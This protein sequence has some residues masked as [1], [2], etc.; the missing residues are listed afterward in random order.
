MLKYAGF[1]FLQGM[2]ALV[3]VTFMTFAL[4][5]VAGDP[6]YSYVRVDASAK[7]I[8]MARERLG[9]NRPLVVQ[10][11]KHVS[12]YAVG[13][14]G[15]SLRP[16]HYPVGKLIAARIPVSFQ[17]A[18]V[19][20]VFIL[21][22][23]VPIGVLA[24]VKRGTVFD[25][26][27]KALALGGQSIPTFWL[28]IVLIVIFAVWLEVLPV[29]GKGGPSSFILPT[30]AAAWSGLAAVV[31]ITRS[32]MLEILGTD[33][34]RTARAKGLS[35]RMVIWTHAFRNALI[36][37]VTLAGLMLG[38]M[39]NGLV[40]IEIIFAWPGLG[41]QGV[42]AVMLRD[43]PVLIALVM[44]TMV[45]YLL[46]NFAVDVLYGLIDPRIKYT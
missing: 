41:A 23:A 6:I 37:I 44:L 42:E 17:L 46:I 25:T 16:H 15:E 39:L 36:P 35:E 34:L 27:G 38:G 7:Q 1:R 12:R 13:D 40:L 2:V 31:R 30:F 22:T 43:F 14:L 11:W 33:Y 4:E 20:F 21:L 29:G 28:A 3:L 10:Y 18:G 45:I 24:A 5:H 8:E 19:V 9:L 26:F 32:S